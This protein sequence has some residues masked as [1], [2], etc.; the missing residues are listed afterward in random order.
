MASDF[1]LRGLAA[2]LLLSTS[3]LSAQAA[4]LG[5]KKPGVL[6]TL[7]T[8]SFNPW[9]VRVRAI[10]VITG[11]SNRVDV[12]GDRMAGIK[13]SASFVPELD[14]TYYFTRNIAAELILATSYHTIKA[15]GALAEEMDDAGVGTK[16]GS[17]W[18]LPPTLTLQY[19]FTDFGAFKP[20]I[21]AGVNYTLFYG[22]KSARAN[23]IR[24]L[25]VQSAVGFA[26]QVGFDYML[27]K[28][29]GINL[30]VKKLYLRPVAKAN[31]ALGPVKAKVKLDPW[32]VGV[33]V[34]YKF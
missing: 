24:H 30:D 25:R 15:K 5:Y 18:A 27:D 14:I 21:G 6:P 2:A 9:Q 19:H 11:G 23:T 3:A 28:N 32:I 12:D 33:G 8:T 16:V 31:S 17:T 13:T 10:G 26:A 7:A 29:W 1:S 4:D 20:Y 34:T 22:E